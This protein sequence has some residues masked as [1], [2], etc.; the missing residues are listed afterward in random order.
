MKR[1]L[2]RS[3]VALLVALAAVLVLLTVFAGRA[4]EQTVRSAGPLLM[5]VPV[6]LD[7]ATVR[8][9]RGY[10]S[11]DG[12]KV[13]N[14]EGFH[15]GHMVSV[16]HVHVKMDVRSMLT[17]TLLISEIVVEE[18]DISYEM[19]LT[20]SNVGKLAARFESDS[21]VDRDMEKHRA[22]K[23][24]KRV[25]IDRL[26]V[27][28]GKVRLSTRLLH[29]VNAP[30]PLPDIEMKDIGKDEETTLG[31]AVARVFKSVLSSTTAVVTSSGKLV[32]D[33]ATAAGSAA[34]ESAKAVGKGAAKAFSG[35]GNL[36]TGGDNAGAQGSNAPPGTAASPEAAKP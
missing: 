31:Q 20:G 7:H 14:P 28:D 4:V 22:G 10:V 34:A 8:I 32:V 1:I 11:L 6:Q 19:S 35:I 13:G 23:P 24:A 9:V 25:R 29:G 15:T 2:V 5:G 26:M 27:K 18:P 30:I 3:A 17:D 12:L 16:K 33:G 36:I 21:P